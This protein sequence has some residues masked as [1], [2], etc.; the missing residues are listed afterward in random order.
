M[1]ANELLQ[2]IYAF[3]LGLVVL[4]FVGI[5]LNTFYPRPPY[6]EDA[7]D[8]VGPAYDAYV[9]L[10][11]AWQINTSII[12]LIAATIVLGIS[13]VR[14]PWP[15]VISNGLLL[16]GIFTMVYAVGMSLGAESS[17]LRFGVATLALAITVAAG[18]LSFRGL[19]RPRHPAVVA[20]G[21]PTEDGGVLSGRVARLEEQLAA[22]RRALD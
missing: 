4:A 8:A 21:Q 19:T 3:F 2:V 6:P 9:K 17:L 15:P 13:L 1:K 12:L 22:L 7:V 10:E 14:G 20:E 11:D 5:G 18:Y 16:G